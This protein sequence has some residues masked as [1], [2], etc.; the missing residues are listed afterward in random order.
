MNLNRTQFNNN[1]I[2][3]NKNNDNSSNHVD[4]V[5][6][7]TMTIPNHSSLR[8]NNKN[9]LSSTNQFSHR[10]EQTSHLTVRQEGRQRRRR[11]RRQTRRD[12]QEQ[13]KTTHTSVT[14]T[15]TT[16]P[17]GSM[18][19]RHDTQQFNIIQRSDRQSLSQNLFHIQQYSDDD[20]DDDYDEKSF[21]FEIYKKETNSQRQ[22]WEQQLLEDIQIHAIYPYLEKRQEE[23][24]QTEMI[25]YVDN[26]IEEERHKHNLLEL[27]QHEITE[28]IEFYLMQLNEP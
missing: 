18:T 20:I 10:P 28:D 14:R 11:R 25:D 8:I 7:F 6:S 15:A 27:C 23:E 4:F 24:E 17:Y 3:N 12:Q 26:I 5:L 22:I 2:Q 19:Y 13:Q 9:S 1:P 21:L 16:Y